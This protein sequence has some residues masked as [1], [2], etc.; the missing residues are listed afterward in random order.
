MASVL[1]E[2]YFVR[3]R[4]LVVEFLCES[5]WTT[6]VADIMY[7]CD[8]DA[9]DILNWDKRRNTLSESPALQG[10]WLL[11]APFDYCLREVKE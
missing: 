5:H 10:Q 11:K 2:K 3:R 7:E 9:V 4:K 1:C 8:R 6:I